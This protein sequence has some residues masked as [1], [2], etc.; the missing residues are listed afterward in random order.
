MDKII[1]FVLAL[2]PLSLLA[3]LGTVDELR[4]RSITVG[5]PSLCAALVLALIAGLKTPRAPDFL[6]RNYPVYFKTGVALALVA[7]VF[8]VC[9]RALNDPLSDWMITPELVAY[10]IISALIGAAIGYLACL[11]FDKLRK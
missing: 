10:G 9:M 1:G 3:V 11:A 4:D 7:I 5:F 2:S 8:H 6:I